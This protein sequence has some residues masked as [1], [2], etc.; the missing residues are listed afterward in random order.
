M[1]Q[2]LQY[3]I[4][5]SVITFPTNYCNYNYSSN[6]CESA[7][8]EQLRTTT[9]NSSI[10]DNQQYFMHELRSKLF[11]QSITISIYS[12]KLFTIQI[13]IVS[14]WQIQSNFYKKPNANNI[15][16][17][18]IKNAYTF[19]FRKSDNIWSYMWWNARNFDYFSSINFCTSSKYTIKALKF[20][21]LYA[22][23]H[24]A[25]ACDKNE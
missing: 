25:Y 2:T 19:L 22:K 11:K 24:F 5:T 15:Q 16:A 6:L 1:N 13:I 12:S 7:S 10:N 4:N 9:I 8:F 20:L 17:N 3:R 14:I 21:L 18:H 23:F